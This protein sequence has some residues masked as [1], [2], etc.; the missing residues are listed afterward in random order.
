V[1]A[2]DQSDVVSDAGV[3]ELLAL[4]P[5]AEYVNVPATGHMV[6]GDDNAVFT[7]R[8]NGFLAGLAGSSHLAGP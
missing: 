8:V 7:R 3:S 1:R 4:I 5:G 6:A 2:G